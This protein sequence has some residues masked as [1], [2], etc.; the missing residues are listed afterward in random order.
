LDRAIDYCLQIADGLAAAHGKGIVHRDLKPEN[1]ILTP[2]ERVKILDFGLAKLSGPAANTVTLDV[3]TD[4]GTVMGTLGY[5]SPE[6]AVGKNLDSRT[7]LFSLGAVLFEMVCGCRAFQGDSSAEVYDA[8]LNC[9]PPSPS[10]LNR[11]L[12]AQ[13]DNIIFKALE[14]DC[15]LRYQVAY[16]IRVDL[17]R[18]KRDLEPGNTVLTFSPADVVS[19]GSGRHWLRLLIPSAIL[20]LLLSGAMTYKSLQSSQAAPEFRVRQLTRNSSENSVRGGAISARSRSHSSEC[21]DR[22][23]A[24]GSGGASTLL[25]PARPR[26][27]T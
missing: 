24:D 12:P 17:K 8:I 23:E 1:L 26:S 13:I 6:Q 5:M 10:Q 4:P 19:A 22:Q 14:K 27:G 7:D 25:R 16:E 21:M 18:L 11:Q 9:T 3:A 20:I 2:E 15:D